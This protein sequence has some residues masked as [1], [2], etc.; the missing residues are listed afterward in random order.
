MGYRYQV[1]EEKA[2]AYDFRLMEVLL[3]KKGRSSVDEEE[4][5]VVAV[6]NH[7]ETLRYVQENMDDFIGN[8]VQVRQMDQKTKKRVEDNASMF[9]RNLEPFFSMVSKTSG[10]NVMETLSSSLKKALLL[11]AMDRY[12]CDKETVCQALG[13]SRE[14]LEREMR[15]CGLLPQTR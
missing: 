9:E 5:R 7:W 10:Q 3:V 11:M 8:I 13:I 4:S 15:H 2:G 12:H 1:S 14:K 6:D